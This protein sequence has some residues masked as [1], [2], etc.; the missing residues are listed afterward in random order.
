MFSFYKDNRDFL[1]ENFKIKITL[2]GTFLFEHIF[3]YLF[4]FKR[5]SL[6]EITVERRKQ[7][8]TQLETV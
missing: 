5:R 7:Y 2:L 4:P 8:A 6:K 3:Y 1:K